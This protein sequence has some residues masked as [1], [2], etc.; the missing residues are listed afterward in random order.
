MILEEGHSNP[1]VSGAKNPTE[2]TLPTANEMNVKPWAYIRVR[3]WLDVSKF[4]NF[5][6]ER[7]DELSRGTSEMG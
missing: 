1:V 2:D 4:K 6:G 7:I 3:E 5:L